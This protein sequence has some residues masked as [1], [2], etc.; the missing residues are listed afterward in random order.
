MERSG[1]LINQSIVLSKMSE[2]SYQSKENYKKYFF[3]FL[4]VVFSL[5][6]IIILILSVRRE[7]VTE[8]DSNEPTLEQN[9][10]NK[11]LS[12]GEIQKTL[13]KAEDTEG[14]QNQI[15]NEDQANNA[16]KKGSKTQEVKPLSNDEIQASLNKRL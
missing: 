6:V 16:L 10:D 4:A 3:I 2:I 13:K 11:A 5:I 8:K 14:S 9:S 12:P 15:V 1:S 7:N